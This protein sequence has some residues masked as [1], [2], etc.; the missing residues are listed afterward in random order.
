MNLTRLFEFHI[1]T[2]QTVSF[3]MQ[4]VEYLPKDWAVKKV[5]NFLSILY[6]LKSS[7]N[8]FMCPLPDYVVH[9]IQKKL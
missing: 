4:A 2:V 5:T 6:L 9:K 3:S 7:E 1:N 8:T